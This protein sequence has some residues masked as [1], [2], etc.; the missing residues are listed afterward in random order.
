MPTTSADTLSARKARW[1]QHLDGQPGHLFTIACYPDAPARP[2][3]WPS[4]RDDR[5]EYA[6]QTYRYM[7]ERAEWLRDDAIPYLNVYTGTE[8]F[9]E[10]FGCSVVR[11]EDDMPFALP[12]IHDA[13]EVAKLQVPELSSS[14]LAYLFDMADELRRRAGDDAVMRLVDIQSPMDIAALIWDKNEFYPAFLDA[15]EAVK[16][17]GAK[18]SALLTAFLDEWFA[19]YGREFIAHYPDYYMPYGLTLS[20]DEVGV[21]NEEMFLEFF[22]PELQALSERYDGLGMHCCAHARHQWANFLRIPKLRVLN[23]VQPAETIRSAFDF[24]ADH[25]LQ[26]HCWG[27]DGSYESWPAQY[28]AGARFVIQASAETRNEALALSEKLWTA[29]GRG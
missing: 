1:R 7:R 24:F 5:V 25:L 19:R 22:L 26:I 17:L 2:L 13:D 12:L 15:P 18:V 16:E 20:E 8:V 3:P 28:P 21:V 29:C 14:S 6:W 23:L 9:A 4:L 10:A 11:R 27:G